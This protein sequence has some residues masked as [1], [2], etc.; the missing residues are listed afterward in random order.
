MSMGYIL[1]AHCLQRVMMHVL[2]L[3]LKQNADST[4]LNMSKYIRNKVF[5]KLLATQMIRRML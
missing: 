4:L 2:H 1:Q 3:S 5:L